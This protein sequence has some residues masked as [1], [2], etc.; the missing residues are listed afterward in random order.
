ME[1]RATQKPALVDRPQGYPALSFLLDVSSQ[2]ISSFLNQSSIPFPKKP[3]E[4]SQIKDLLEKAASLSILEITEI[5]RS[6]YFPDPHL[7]LSSDLPKCGSQGRFGGQEPL[8]YLRRYSRPILFS[9]IPSGHSPLTKIQPFSSEKTS[10]KTEKQNEKR[11]KAFREF[12]AEFIRT[13]REIATPKQWQ[14]ARRLFINE[15][16]QQGR[17]SLKDMAKELNIPPST[18]IQQLYGRPRNGGWMGGLFPKAIKKIRKNPKAL[19]MIKM[20]KR[21]LKVILMNHQEV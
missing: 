21:L 15:Y 7:I 14:I 19:A 16:Y 12:L 18:F 10:R 3:E 13:T 9:E 2:E 11:I 20:E 6:S 8:V 1:K 5:Q 4:D 17:V